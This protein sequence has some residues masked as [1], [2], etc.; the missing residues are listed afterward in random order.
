MQKLCVEKKA[1]NRDEKIANKMQ[2]RRKRYEFGIDTVANLL[3]VY[4]LINCLM[5][6]MNVNVNGNFG[7][8][9]KPFSSSSFAICCELS[10]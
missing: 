8:C 2:Y 6:F 4:S 10:H 1:Q 7:L 5:L 9:S 3:V